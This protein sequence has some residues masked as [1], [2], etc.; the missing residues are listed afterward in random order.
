MR[1]ATLNEKEAFWP[2]AAHTMLASIARLHIGNRVC[3]VSVSL[4]PPLRF[5]N[6]LCIQ[7]TRRKGRN[8]SVTIG[9]EGRNEPAQ[10]S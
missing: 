6:Y 5:G 7:P 9:F 4:L 2:R 8:P 1:N 10:G 3:F